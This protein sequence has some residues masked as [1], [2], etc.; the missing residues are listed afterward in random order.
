VQKLYRL[1]S[2]MSLAGLLIAC[3]PSFQPTEVK[4]VEE[5]AA[6]PSTVSTNPSL[7]CLSPALK[8]NAERAAHTATLLPDGKV[9][10][11]GGFR[12]EGTSEVAISSAEIFDP[13]TNTFTPTRDLNEPRN[14][15]TATLLPNGKVLLAGGWN[16]HGRTATAEVYDPQ[17]GA[18]EYTGSLMAPRQGLTATL[19]SNGQV[20]IAG[21][22]SARNSPQLAAELYDP[23][24]GTFTLAENLNTGRFGHTATLLSD[25]K[26][27]LVGGTSG[28]DNI[29]SSA[30]LYN[31]ETGIFTST[32]DAN[33]I[34]YKHA[35]VRLEDGNV[36]ILGGTDQSDWDGKYDSAEIYNS[37]TGTFIQI[38]DM[39]QERFKLA[40]AAVLLSDG[41]VLVGGGNRQIEIFDS[42]TQTFIPDG[43]LDDDYYFSVLT[44]LKDGQVLIT[45]GYNR[46]ILPSDRAWLYC[47]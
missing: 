6:S 23:A 9:L 40:E 39:N 16:Q 10:I 41:N 2:I 5:S 20:L 17:T 37:S 19:L 24:T 4:T 28:N 31:P 18:F 38:S 14:G 12:E 1:F 30:E 32:E 47:G 33:V 29:L 22:D 45:G 7:N 42:Q 3:V 21:G 11:A 46:N 15:H 13:A 27:L 25:G 36:L 8:M 43:T 26:V 44:M 35:A 34:R